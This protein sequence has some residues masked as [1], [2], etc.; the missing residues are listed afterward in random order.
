M[1]QYNSAGLIDQLTVYNHLIEG[2]NELSILPTIRIEQVITIKN[3]KGRLPDGFKSLYSA[4]KCEPYGYTVDSEEPKDILMDIYHYKVRETK[5]Q[6][7]QMCDPCDVTV[8]DSCI[9]EK[10]YFHNGT[11]GN[12]YYNNLKP[13]RLKLAPYIKRTIC[14]KDCLNFKSDKAVDEISINGKTVYSNFKEGNIFLVYNGYEEDEEGFLIIPE[15]EENNLEKYL[16][17][18]IKKEIIRKILENSDNTTNE[19]LLLSMY[20]EDLNTYK[21]RTVGEYKMKSVMRSVGKYKQELRKEFEVY[22]FGSFSRN[23]RNRIEFIVT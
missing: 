12:F 23:Q 15:S 10:V 11:R 4:V 3:N 8:T 22:N 5:N 20:Q 17:A 14:D 19:Q 13:L 9:V 6:E 7:W 16:R 18:Y 2:M 1:E 21:T